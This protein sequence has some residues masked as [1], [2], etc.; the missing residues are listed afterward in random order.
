MPKIRQYADRDALRELRGEIEAQ[1]CR[2]GF[3]SQRALAE[4]LGVSQGTVS[5]WL[6]DLDAVSIGAMRVMVKQLKLDPAVVLK[7][8]GYTNKD[9]KEKFK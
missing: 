9:I 5:N 2:M 7:A 4:P 8:L 6:R 3:K 1:G